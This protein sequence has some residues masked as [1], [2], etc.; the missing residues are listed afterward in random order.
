MN[1]LTFDIEEWFHILD[2]DSTKSEREWN[3]FPTR[4]HMNMETIF[5]VLEETETK[6]SFFV[7]GWIAEKYPNVVREICDRGYEIGS[8]TTFHQLVYNQDR[9][10]FFQEICFNNSIC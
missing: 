9:N 4:I 6:A 8:H 1:I 7:L 2:N 10:S 3:N 5:R